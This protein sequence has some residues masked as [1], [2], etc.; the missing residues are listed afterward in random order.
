MPGT[1]FHK[2]K[3]RK[4]RKMVVGRKLSKAQLAANEERYR[5]I[6]RVIS[7]YTFSTKLMPDGS[8]QLDWVAGASEAITGYTYEEYIAR[9]GWL[10]ALHPDDIEKDANDIVRLRMNQPVVSEVRTIARDGKVHWVRVYAHPVWDAER[11]ALVGIYGAV[12]DVSERRQVEIEREALIQEL[13]AKNAELERF[14]YTVSHDLKSP[15]ITIQGFL[16]YLEQD[17]LSGNTERLRADIQRI[18]NAAKKMERLLGELLE[19]SRIGRLMTPPVD[20]PFESLVREAL[21]LTEGR[22]K[23]RNIRVLVDPQLP[24][25]HG[26]P[27]RLVEVLQNLI[28]NSA[29]FMGSQP[30]PLIHIGL[31]QVEGQPAFFVQDN[32]I[33]IEPQFQ[34]KVFGLFDKLD[35]KS[36]GTGIGLAIV[37]RIVEVHGGKIWLH[38]SGQNSGTTFYFT[39]PIVR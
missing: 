20:I 35:P 8:L 32:G 24:S 28:D 19:L 39:L 31:A 15:L 10:A 27:H 38:S 36:E 16:G 7:D 29:K 3:L 2:G 12:Q 4:P 5:L 26:D 25:V 18:N 17:A 23:E 9:G 33:G 21:S 6:S 22:L 37:K 14:T 34:P 30:D 13:E 1:E 11:N